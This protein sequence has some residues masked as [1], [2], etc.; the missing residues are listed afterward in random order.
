MTSQADDAA[1]EFSP[2]AA[3]SS[4]ERR[5]YTDVRVIE[6]ILAETKTIAVVGLSRDPVKP[7]HY[8][9]AYMQ[10]AGYRV[11][12]VTPHAG[13]ILGEVSF[14]ALASLPGPVDLVL[15][16]RPGPECLSVAEQ[17]IAIGAPRIWFQLHIQCGEGA[18]KAAAAGVQVVADRCIMVEH[19]AIAG[20]KA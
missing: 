17:A 15:V 2:Q 7:S 14:P 20:Q 6:R 16:F 10:R 8:V 13:T 3:L 18:R 12:P 4:E 9:P 19:K 11:I 5:R 1:C